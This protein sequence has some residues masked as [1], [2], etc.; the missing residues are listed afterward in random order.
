LKQLHRRGTN[1]GRVSTFD[2]QF[3]LG[4]LGKMVCISA[5]PAAFDR[6]PCGLTGHVAHPS[7]SIETRLR[8]RLLVATL[9][10]LPSISLIPRARFARSTRSL[11]SF[12]IR[13]LHSDAATAR[14]Q[15]TRLPLQRL[16]SCIV[17]S[18]VPCPRTTASQERLMIDGERTIY[19]CFCVEAMR[20]QVRRLLPIRP[21]VSVG[22]VESVNVS[23][24]ASSRA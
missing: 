22:A 1:W 24:A 19:V 18:F 21:C 6:I 16:S 14:T 4:H 9:A 2:I 5:A 3:S 7:R 11:H 12:R 17:A 8:P 13:A 20:F 15:P 10:T 23:L